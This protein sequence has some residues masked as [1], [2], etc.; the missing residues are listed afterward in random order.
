MPNYL[1]FTVRDEPGVVAS[2]QPCLALMASTYR[3]C[4]NGRCTGRGSTN[5]LTH[6]AKEHD[7]VQA[8]AA[9]RTSMPSWHRHVVSE[10]SRT[11]NADYAIHTPVHFAAPYA[12][13]KAIYVFGLVGS[14]GVIVNLLF[15][16]LTLLLIDDESIASAIGIFVSVFTNF[17]NDAW[18]WGDRHKRQVPEPFL[19]GPFN[20]TSS[21]V[22]VAIQLERQWCLSASTKKFGPNHWNRIGDVY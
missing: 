7:L 16:W 3:K 4:Y 17:L 1:R 12:R 15:V 10:S 13:T 14:S 5:I 18:T 20:T 19:L 6:H 8:L 2:T 11:F 22:A 9:Y 21:G